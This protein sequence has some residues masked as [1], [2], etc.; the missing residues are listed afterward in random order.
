MAKK[1]SKRTSKS[2]SPARPAGRNVRSAR[3]A[4]P[5]RAVRRAAAPPRAAA[6]ASKYR[7]S[8]FDERTH[9]PV[10]EQHARRLGSFIETMADGVVDDAELKAQEERLVKLMQDVE[11]RLDDTLHE[12]VTRLLYELTAY[13]LMQVLHAMQ[14]QRPT[15]IFRG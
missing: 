15:T 2:R 7:A 13:D 12:K 6:K 11:P 8:W 10:I 14:Q 9:A 5:K 1:K 4:A 3:S